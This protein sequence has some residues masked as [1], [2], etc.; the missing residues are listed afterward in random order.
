VDGPGEGLRSTWTGLAVNPWAVDHGAVRAQRKAPQA[1]CAS[2]LGGPGENSPVGSHES[3]DTPGFAL[4]FAVGRRC[5]KGGH[6]CQRPA[7]GRRRRLVLSRRLRD[8]RD[9]CF[10]S[11]WTARQSLRTR[12]RGFRLPLCL[13]AC[14]STRSVAGGAMFVCRGQPGLGRCFRVCV[15]AILI[16]PLWCASTRSVAPRDQSREGRCVCVAVNPGQIGD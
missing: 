9:R 1:A 16:A 10:G 5:E 4:A 6:V 11:G 12:L 7:L 3:A 2:R 14:A 13:H 8:R 15:V